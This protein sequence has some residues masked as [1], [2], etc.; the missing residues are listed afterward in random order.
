MSSDYLLIALI[1]AGFGL[2]GVYF[3]AGYVSWRRYQAAERKKEL[4]LRELHANRLRDE[5]DVPGSS[6]VQVVD[7]VP[8]AHRTAEQMKE[9]V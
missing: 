9:V 6:T 5:N 1:V 3:G 2:S 8:E 7:R 4:S